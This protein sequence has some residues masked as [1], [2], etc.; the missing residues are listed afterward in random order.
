[1][2]EG[3]RVHT[4]RH[5]TLDLRRR[6]FLVAAAAAALIAGPYPFAFASAQSAVQ[7]RSSGGAIQLAQAESEDDSAPPS[8]QVEKYIAV[9]SAMQHDHNLT[10]DQAASK[11][12]LTV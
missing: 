12:G 2:P 7:R 8:D 3:F 11:E 1:M 4:S 9:Y 5:Q 10:V 6:S